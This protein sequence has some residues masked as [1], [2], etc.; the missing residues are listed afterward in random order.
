MVD[1][2]SNTQIQVVQ[3]YL[4]K[5]PA[6]FIAMLIDKPVES[7]RSLINE[8][9][10]G[11]GRKTFD[12]RT[13]KVNLKKLNENNFKQQDK[14]S[15]NMRDAIIRKAPVKKFETKAVDYTKL[16]SVRVD[17]KTVIMIRPGQ[18]PETE[19][20]KFLNSRQPVVEKHWKQVSKFK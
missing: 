16:I 11:T 12:S 15:K 20:Q 10:E 7:V 4:E 5:K 18:D 14:T 13:R 19:K 2:F 3:T 1:Q 6:G 9:I 17:H 8:L